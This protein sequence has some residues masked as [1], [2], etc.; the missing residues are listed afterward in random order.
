MKP[1]TSS[2]GQ[3]V[4]CELL[5]V[6]A[7]MTTRTSLI[8]GWLKKGSTARRE[9]GLAADRPILLGKVAA[10][11]LALAGGDDQGGDAHRRRAL[12]AALSARA[13]L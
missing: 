2:P 12:G 11:A 1:P 13:L 3:S 9:H 7:A 4:A 8:A 10:E 5:P 6:P